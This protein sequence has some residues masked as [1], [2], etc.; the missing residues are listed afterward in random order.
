MEVEVEGIVRG[1]A[2]SC[3]RGGGSR[4]GNEDEGRSG[5][6]EQKVVMEMEG[7]D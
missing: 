1:L 3:V 4:R 2:M 5:G 7:G 6:V